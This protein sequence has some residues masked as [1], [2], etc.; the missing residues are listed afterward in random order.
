MSW[1]ARIIACRRCRRFH[2][3]LLDDPR[4]VPPQILRF[5]QTAR[6]RPPLLADV[7]DASETPDDEVAHRQSAAP[8]SSLT[9]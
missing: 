6:D 4:P 2:Y 5:L 3:V 9:Y 1:S 7:R 8:G